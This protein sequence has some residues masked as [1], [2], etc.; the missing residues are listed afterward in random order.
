MATTNS[1]YTKL[2]PTCASFNAM[3]RHFGVVTVMNAVVYD[4]PENTILALKK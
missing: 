1:S 3:L 4:I 2:R